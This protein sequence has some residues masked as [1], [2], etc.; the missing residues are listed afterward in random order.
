M[1]KNYF[2]MLTPRRATP[3][4]VAPPRGLNKHMFNEDYCINIE[5]RDDKVAKQQAKVYI[6]SFKGH[7]K[8]EIL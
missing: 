1:K 8:L 2:Y 7:T 6:L 4:C 3:F 5:F